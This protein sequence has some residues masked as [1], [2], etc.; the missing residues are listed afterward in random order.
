MSTNLQ[1]PATGK[2]STVVSK[3]AILQ[4]ESIYY[5]DGKQI[6]ELMCITRGREFAD[7]A[8]EM[9]DAGISHAWFMPDHGGVAP[10]QPIEEDHNHPYWQFFT[11]RYNR[12]KDLL[13]ISA[14]RRP[15]GQPGRLAIQMIMFEN[16]AWYRE[17]SHWGQECTPKELLTT[18]LYLEKQLKISM[19][20]GP[21]G[22]G[23]RLLKERHT[24]WLNDYPKIDLREHH[25][26][27]AAGHDIVWRSP[28]LAR[29]EPGVYIHKFDRG[30]AFPYAAFFDNRY[31]T[32]T[33][34]HEQGEQSFH[35]QTVK[36]TWKND[37]VGVW[38][39]TVTGGAD[40]RLPTLRHGE[41]ISG[42]YIRAL[43]H[44]GY[45]VEIHEGYVFSESAE[46]MPHEMM[47]R[48]AKDMWDA[49]QAFRKSEDWK[50]QRARKFAEDS[51][52]LIAVATIGSTAFKDYDDQT[53][54]DKRRPDIR[55]QTIGRSAELTVLTILAEQK[56]S[57]RLPVMVYADAI[58]YTLDHADGR[59][60]FPGI[61][62]REGEFGGMRHEGYKLITPDIHQILQSGKP[63]SVMLEMLNESGWT[64]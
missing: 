53:E 60:A 27:P 4:G 50:N 12:R 39:C 28:D 44:L 49:R 59:G 46:S 42:P 13:L 56:R 47:A 22:V 21:G 20:A 5:Y 23:W 26:T 32:G 40:P 58:Y 61:V 15:A 34:L 35:R 45:T 11:P 55:L 1:K 8:V 48:W 31:G 57:G 41:W 63:E 7:I 64:E 43:R 16:T 37:R 10:A 2:S 14:K 24:E 52:K 19:G 18:I 62:K 51:C 33:P 6:Q 3:H 36:G 9:L 38:R 25:F 29:L 17:G 54:A 30:M